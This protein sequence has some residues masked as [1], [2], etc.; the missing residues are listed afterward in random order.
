MIL[1]ILWRGMGINNEWG[2]EKASSDAI[3]KKKL[4]NTVK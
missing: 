2:S 4:R 3:M 1:I